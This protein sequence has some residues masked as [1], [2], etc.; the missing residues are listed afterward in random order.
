MANLL[1]WLNEQ[2]WY[3]LA[4]IIITFIFWWTYGCESTVCSLIDS[5]KQVNR[6]ELKVEIEYVAGI[7]KTRISDLD[8]KDEIKKALFDSL[9][10]I[11]E[12]GQINAAGL[13][14]LV[15]TISAISWGLKKNQ[16]LKN[17][18]QTSTIL[19]T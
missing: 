14:N 3:I 13:V 12:G 6:A 5:T 2:H 1:K 15:A 7:A 17:V 18:N 16:Q 8:K 4:L 10:L 11:G 19:P 9:V